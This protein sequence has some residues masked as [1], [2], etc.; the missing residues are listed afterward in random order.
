MS[1][2]PILASKVFPYTAMETDLLQFSGNEPGKDLVKAGPIA[3]L[4]H[5][6]WTSL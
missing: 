5:V 1:N 4:A 3:D 2:I 6:P